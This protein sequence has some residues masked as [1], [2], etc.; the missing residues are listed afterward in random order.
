MPKTRSGFKQYERNVARRVHAERIP[1]TGRTGPLGDPGDVDVPGFYVEVRS[2]A[3]ARPLRWIAEA[4]RAAK[5]RG[6]K[7]MVVF[8]GPAPHLSPLVVLRWADFAEV[9][10]RAERASRVR[11][12]AQRPGPAGE[13]ATD[14]GG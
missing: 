6:R 8:R 10:N 1:V 12:D 5:P 9:Y 4:W 11:P 2:R 13:A 14:A 7:P 3:R